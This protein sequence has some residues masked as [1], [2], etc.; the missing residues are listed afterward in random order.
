MPY[1]KAYLSA[2]TEEEWLSIFTSVLQGIPLLYI[3][4]DVELLQS[5]AELTQSF[6]WPTAFL[7]IFS[8]LSQRNI[9]TVIKVALVGYGSPVFRRP[10]TGELQKLVVLVGHMRSGK[11]TTRSAH[12]KSGISM[13]GRIFEQRK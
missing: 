9:R 4:I 8:G 13:R 3:I 7:K 1:L 2:T 12:R 5:L 10:M 11:A 6:S